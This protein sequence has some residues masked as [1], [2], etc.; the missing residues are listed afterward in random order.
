MINLF[1]NIIYFI[2]KPVISAVLIKKNYPEDAIIAK[3]AQSPSDIIFTKDDDVIMFHAVSVGEINAIENLVKKTREKFPR[4]KILV[5]TGTHTGQDLA[6]KKFADIADFITYFPF[7]FPIVIN[8]FLDKFNPKKVFIAE[9]EIWPFFAMICKKR[10]INISII[11][12]RISD[13]TFGSYKTFKYLFKYFLSF[14]TGIYT[15][16]DDDNNKFLQLGSNP[17]TT[18]KMNNLKFDVSKPIV[19]YNIDKASSKILLAG[20]T[21]KGED[22]IV[23][24]TYRKLKETTPGLKLIIAPRHLTRVEEVRALVESFGFIYRLRS[25]G[26][27]SL[28]DIDVLILDTLGELGQMYSFADIAFIGGSFNKTGGHNPLEALVFNKPVISGP[29]VHNFKDIYDIIKKAHA[30]FVVENKNE[31]YEIASELL[32]NKNFYD[33]TVTN[34]TQVFNKQQ[35]ALE[36][37]LDLIKN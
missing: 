1:A 2:I 8:K 33:S 13:R 9:T 24:F 28:K 23:L 4:K 7:D 10:G 11:N 6:K 36:F 5:T 27:H 34:C 21:H 3:Y 32:Q 26:I 31:F 35:G 29:S 17:L 12:G 25:E 20:S 14:Y 30:G 22:E 37:V 19:S 18:K 16:S 15:Q